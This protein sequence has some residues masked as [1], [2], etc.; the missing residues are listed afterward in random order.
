MKIRKLKQKVM[1]M[2]ICLVVILGMIFVKTYAANST[3]TSFSRRAFLKWYKS[4]SYG[5]TATYSDSNGATH[6]IY[7]KFT[8]II[9]NADRG[10]KVVFLLDMVR[11]NPIFCLELGVDTPSGLK[12]NSYTISYK[13]LFDGLD[14][15]RTT[16]TS[17]SLNTIMKSS[18]NKIENGIL[19]YIMCNRYSNWYSNSKFE[20]LHNKDELAA[21]EKDNSDAFT[22][23]KNNGSSGS[24]GHNG[25]SG[26]SLFMNVGQHAFWTYWR[27]WLMSTA[28][29]DDDGNNDATGSSL[30]DEIYLYA[31]ENWDNGNTAYTGTGDDSLNALVT[32][33]KIVSEG[34]NLKAT[35]TKYAN[36]LKS[37]NEFSV[38][39][40]EKV[41]NK[42]TKY[43]FKESSSTTADCETT[44]VTTKESNKITLR[45]T[46]A[47]E[48]KEDNGSYIVGPICINFAKNAEFGSINSIGL[49]NG[50][51]LLAN[52]SKI[53]KIVKGDGTERTFTKEQIEIMA[54]LT[55]SKGQSNACD[56]KEVQAL[57]IEPKDKIYM[58]ID[59]MP[60]TGI[61]S[62]SIK[63]RQVRQKRNVIMVPIF[64]AG[65]DKF[66]EEDSNYFKAQRFIAMDPQPK[67]SIVETIFE[68]PMTPTPTTETGNLKIVKTDS[69]GNKW[70]IQGIKFAV[71]SSAGQTVAN[72]ETDAN[73]ETTTVELPVGTYTIKETSVPTGY[74]LRTDTE[75]VAITK[76]TTK[77]FKFANPA[78][79][80]TTGKL[81]IIKT[82]ADGTKWAIK[83]I[84]FEVIS[85]TGQTVASLE[86]DANGEATT[87]ELEEGTY[88]IKEVSV[89]AGYTIRTS[90]DTVTVKRD[91]TVEHRFANPTSPT[92]KIAGIVWLDRPG[93]MGK[94]TVLDYVYNAN[95]DQVVAGVTVKLQGGSKGTQ[96]TKTDS[97]GRYEFDNV[98]TSELEDLYVEFEYNGQKYQSVPKLQKGVI[99]NGSITYTSTDKYDTTVS[100][101]EEGSNRTAYTEKYKTIDSN[102]GLTYTETTSGNQKISKVNYDSF[103]NITA[104]TKLAGINF[105][106][107]DMN[108]DGF[109]L[110]VNLGLKERPTTDF[111]LFK[112]IY[113]AS[114]TKVNDSGVEE[115]KGSQVYN[116]RSQNGY[117]GEWAKIVVDESLIYDTGNLIS[118]N[119][120]NS[121]GTFAGV[122]LYVDYILELE[123]QSGVIG[124]PKDI[125]DYY[126]N[127]IFTVDSVSY[128]RRSG[129]DYTATESV[130]YSVTNSELKI[131]NTKSLRSGEKVYILV[132]QKLKD[133]EGT[134]GSLPNYNPDD[135]TTR[136]TSINYAEIKSYYT[137]EGLIDV[138]SAP[139]NLKIGQGLLEDDEAK[140]PKFIIRLPD[141]KEVTPSITGT[142]WNDVLSATATGKNNATAKVGNGYNNPND[143]DTDRNEKDNPRAGVEVKIEK[144]GGTWS[145]T[146]TTGTDGKYKF[147]PP[148]EG[149]YHVSYKIDDGQNY[150]ATIFNAESIDTTDEN[151]YKNTTNSATSMAKEDNARRNAINGE[152]EQSKSTT[153]EKKEIWA[154]TP[155]FKL[156]KEYTEDMSDPDVKEYNIDFGV[157]RRPESRL[158]VSVYIDSIKVIA[159]DKVTVISDSKDLIMD[160]TKSGKGLKYV[161]GDIDEY[162]NRKDVETKG[163]TYHLEINDSALTN[164]SVIVVYKAIVR[165]TG[166]TDFT[167]E[168]DN[169]SER[170]ERDSSGAYIA[171]GDVVTTAINELAVY[172]PNSLIFDKENSD[173]GWKEVGKDDFKNSVKD[174]VINSLSN[175]SIIITDGESNIKKP[176]IPNQ[177]EESKFQVSKVIDPVTINSGDI[178]L[179]TSTEA[180]KTENDVG[181]SLTGI[182]L[183][184][185][186]PTLTEGKVNLRDTAEDDIELVFTPETGDKK[187]PYIIAI[188]G[189][190]ILAVGIIIIKKKT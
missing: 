74:T 187:I 51:T 117:E 167:G 142:V 80:K 100:K 47:I 66:N 164:S 4:A 114:V 65:G 127:S 103:P 189:L 8:Q 158:T 185:M 29:K 102:S 26:K 152:K 169:Y 181:K 165:N 57:N 89:P 120:K 116:K 121:S 151:W 162:K 37:L 91:T 183:G 5:D 34:K 171:K 19:A 22:Y 141:V 46:D 30:G 81:K 85:S 14:T 98:N 144:E 32:K 61:T 40:G 84:K 94:E 7:T 53:T 122:Q 10:D 12:A 90:T 184:D 107:A 178:N 50:N 55:D 157:A 130:Q 27:T 24:I 179:T 133:P 140:S 28:N 155:S 180:T 56:R 108:Q 16:D 67:D 86:T 174:E 1:L 68:V 92:T 38:A 60:D 176:L 9:N 101:A 125:V 39:S 105:E 93:N 159:S 126:D 31:P 44:A 88:T 150:E 69:S 173:Q 77:E 177:E 160:S 154:N 188:S 110:N 163:T 147:I 132:R 143:L 124:M 25:Y 3:L 11:R 71:I 2:I 97:S 96:T 20:K 131:A 41:G 49:Y 75:T 146:A 168:A 48:I 128:A 76:N 137:D 113:K 109:R 161:A 52:S 45:N 36:Y 145:E 83:G 82:Y 58:K 62:L 104:S 149:T 13:T 156:A 182:K 87:G 43:E 73:G 64:E 106:P 99:S 17:N 190:T 134:L 15:K 70:A 54:S 119:Y 72:L 42:E 78:P 59:N 175:N 33:H 139:G 21:L 123:N 136:K 148:E 166:D 79:E 95:V 6:K 153:D 129:T 111:A 172:I 186:D 115:E 170:Y 112:D 118:R 63:V 23:F 18:T 135:E 35:A 138:D